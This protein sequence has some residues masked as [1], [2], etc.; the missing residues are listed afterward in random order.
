MQ[1]LGQSL[2][3]TKFGTPAKRK[4]YVPGWVAG[5]QLGF[6][7]MTEPNTGSDLASLR[8]RAVRDGADWRVTGAKTWITHASRSDLMTLLVRTNPDDKGYGGLSMLLAEKPRG[9][10]TDP[11][12]APGMKGGEIAVLGYRGMRE[13]ELSFDGFRVAGDGLLGGVAGQ[14]FKQLMATFESARIQTAARA[15]GVAQ[16]AF[17]IGLSYARERQ[18]FGKALYAFPRVFGKLAWMAV[19]TMIAGVLHMHDAKR[20]TQAAVAAPAAKPKPKAQRAGARR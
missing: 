9:T 5:T 18:Q 6:F 12:P 7:A 11:F 8:T 20:W 15:V 17:E 1:N 16:N 19:E 10:E 13:Y 14:G 2:T 4:K 3:V